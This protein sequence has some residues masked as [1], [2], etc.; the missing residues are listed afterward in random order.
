MCMVLLR[1][2]SEE[3]RRLELTDQKGLVRGTYKNKISTIEY[4]SIHSNKDT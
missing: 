2:C 3:V 1:L 4:V